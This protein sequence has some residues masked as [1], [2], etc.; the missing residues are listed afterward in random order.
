MARLERAGVQGEFCP[1]LNDP[2]DEAYWLEQP[3]APWPALDDEKGTPMTV[4]YD[5]LIR[6]WTE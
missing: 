1:T 5:K 2:R 3:G 4:A 6:R